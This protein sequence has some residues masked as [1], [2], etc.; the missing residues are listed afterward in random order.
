MIGIPTVLAHLEQL[1]CLW[2]KAFRGVDE[3]HRGVDGRQHP[4][5]VFGEVGV[6]GR[7]EQVDDGR[8]VRELQRR[9]RDRDASGL[10]HLHP[11]RHRRATARFAVDRARFGDGPGVQRQRLGQRGLA[12]VG[13]ADDGEGPAA[14]RLGGDTARSRGVRG[15]RIGEGVVGHS[16]LDGIGSRGQTSNRTLRGEE[17]GADLRVRETS[18]IDDGFQTDRDRPGQL[19]GPMLDIALSYLVRTELRPP[20][21]VQ[22]SRTMIAPITEP[23]NPDGWKKPSVASLWKSR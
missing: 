4:V 7:I 23:I 11:V 19:P 8:A 2:L 21:R 16:S 12:R 14:L 3:H 15:R 22:I 10:L 13:M 20:T 6:A 18:S 17:R 1:Q 9:R 5:G